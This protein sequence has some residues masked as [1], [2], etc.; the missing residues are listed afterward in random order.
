MPVKKK[1]YVIVVCGLIG[2]VIILSIR[3]LSVCNMNE[4]FDYSL[5]RESSHIDLARYGWF[6][7]PGTEVVVRD[8]NGAV[9]GKWTCRGDG[10]LK[11]E[12]K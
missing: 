3:S 7:F 5:K 9:Q 4:G 11:M 10:Q 8:A 12:S 6:E 2:G 1:I